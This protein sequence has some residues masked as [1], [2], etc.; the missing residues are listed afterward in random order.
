[1]LVNPAK[2]P[3]VKKE[4]GQR[5]IDWLISSEGQNAIAGYK[6]GGQQLFYPNANDPNA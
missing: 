6:I 2:H 5:F 1:M 4:P 3:T